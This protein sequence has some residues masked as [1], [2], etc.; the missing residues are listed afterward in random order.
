MALFLAL[1]GPEPSTSWAI[2]DAVCCA[3]WCYMMRRAIKNK[4]AVADKVELTPDQRARI[5]VGT[6]ALGS[7]LK[8]VDLELMIAAREKDRV[9]SDER[10]DQEAG[11]EGTDRRTD[12]KEDR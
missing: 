2:V 5:K 4:V 7:I 6:E 9:Q 1:S 10:T 3:Y 8:E 12:S 11:K